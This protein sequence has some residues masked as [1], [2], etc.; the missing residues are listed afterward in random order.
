MKNFKRIAGILLALMLVLSLSSM[1]FAMD[2]NGSIT[3]DNPIDGQTYTAYK[4][5]DVTYNADKSTYSYTIAGDSE[6]FSTVQNYNGVTLT[7]AASG[8]TY[9]VTKND[10]YKAADFA[11]A[12]KAAS[13]GK[14]GTTLTDNGDG[15]VGVSN[16]P[17]GYYF[18]SSTSGALCNL[19]TTDPSVT[20]HDKNDVPFEKND[21]KD[22]VEVGETVNYEILGKVPDTTGFDTYVYTINDTMT[23]GLTFNEDVSITVGGEA[24]SADKYVYDK[25]GN[26]FTLTIHVKDLQD[27]V[28]EEIKVE[29]SAVVNENAIAKVSKNSAILTYSNNPSDSTST[30]PT[31]PDEETVYCAKIVIDKFEKG[32]DAK[33]L[34]DAKFVLTNADG[35]YYKYTAGAAAKVEWVDS[36]DDATEVTTDAQGAAEFGGLKDGAYYLIETAAPDGYNRLT[37][38]VEI[39]IDGSE[40]PLTGNETVLTLTS[41]VENNKGSLLP[42]TGGM[43]TTLFYILGGL[44]VLGAGVLMVTRRRMRTEK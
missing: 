20:I 18:V 26:G 11:N 39:Q 10:N 34:A 3:V 1:A 29:Y 37:E 16:L 43:G 31:L 8:N 40:A 42:G 2:S 7:K 13:A 41:Q 35:K 15:T 28:G 19:T 30:V 17:L 25:N 24:L 21:D 6:W 38:S 36:I 44:L 32:N 14:T 33:K 27:K 4:I 5:F 22:S 9:V 12:L 23:D